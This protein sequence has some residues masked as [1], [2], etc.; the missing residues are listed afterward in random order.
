MPGPDLLRVTDAGLFCEA[1]DFHIDPWQPVD[2]AVIT[3]AHSDH[4]RAGSHSYLC[5][6]EGVALLAHR[7]PGSS[8]QGVAWGERRT[9]NGVTIS[10]HP[11]GHIRG[12]AQ[13]RVEHRG[14]TWVA[15]GDYKRH[16]D[17][18]CHPF[19]VVRCHTFITEATFALPVYRWS[20]PTAVVADIVRW[21]EQVRSDGGCAVLLTY[22][23]GKAQRLL[24]E[25]TPFLDAPVLVHGA[26]EPLTAIYRA[27]GVALAPTILV[28]DTGKRVKHRGAF[29][30]AP[31]SAAV[32]GWLRRFNE[33]QVGFASGWMR[34]RGTRRRRALDRGFGLSDHVD[35]TGLLQ[36]IA[37]TGATRV[38]ATHGDSRALVRY[39]QDRGLEA[40]ALATAYAAEAEAAGDE[41]A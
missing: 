21:Y 2:R 14:E 10:L 26:V 37:E 30:I 9:L 29:V 24:A 15:S 25:L 32:P 35:W 7:L 31:P 4:A 16:G 8:I 27:A 5:A 12:A 17:P 6:E 34:L 1:G 40:G 36:T 11:A 33:P 38:L 28:R 19:E 23:L 13:V 41:G 22:T 39:L 3:H 18:T 20:T